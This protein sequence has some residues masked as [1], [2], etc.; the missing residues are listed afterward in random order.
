ML[1]QP[2]P[3]PLTALP[4]TRLLTTQ[5][6]YLCS[7]LTHA[8]KSRGVNRKTLESGRAR[9]STFDLRAPPHSRLQAIAALVVSNEEGPDELAELCFFAR[10]RLGNQAEHLHSSWGARR[11]D[12]L[13]ADRLRHLCWLLL[14]H[15]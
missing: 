8:R 11:V 15:A 10:S 6:L 3:H 12:E 14:Q 5:R 2:R 7:L 13:P 1:T 4:R 9:V